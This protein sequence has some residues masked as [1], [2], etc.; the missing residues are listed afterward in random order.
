MPDLDSG[1]IFLTTLAPI[2]SAGVGGAERTSFAQNIRMALTK[3]PT[4]MQS[5]ATCQT[6]INS[7]FARNRRTHLARMFVLDDVIYNGRVGRDAITASLLKDDPSVLK[8]AEGL[9]AAYLVFCADIDAV[10]EDGQ[11]LPDTLTPTRQRKVREAYARELWDTMGPELNEIYANCEGFDSVKTGD[12]FAAYLERCHIETTMP[13]HD[14]YLKLPKFNL[15]PVKPLIV[16]VAVPAIVTLIAL[17]IRI[18]GF[19]SLPW[20]GWSTLGTFV[21]ALALTGAVAVLAI[22]FALANGEKPLA[23]GEYDDLPSVL[24]ALFVRQRFADFVVD[25]QG[26]S[27]EDLHAAFG[28]FLA[29]QKPSDVTGPTQE[30][31]VIS[32]GPATPVS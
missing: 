8:K 30:P 23:P 7:P 28:D 17:M 4:A 26:G 5:P 12:D 16:S 10:T 13:F 11:K 6:G 22:R 31:G 24:K 27:A 14:Y 18:L 20:L 1:H 19:L 25:H 9:N 29:T 32:S 2:K 21:I 15:L 3:L